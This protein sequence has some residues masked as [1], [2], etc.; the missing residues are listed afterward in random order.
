VAQAGTQDET[1]HKQTGNPNEEILHT[2]FL[3]HSI[4]APIRTFVEHFFSKPIQKGNERGKEKQRPQKRIRPVPPLCQHKGHECHTTCMDRT[5]PASLGRCFGIGQH[6]EGKQPQTTILK[7][8]AESRAGIAVVGK[9]GEFEEECG[10]K[11]GQP[12]IKTSSPE[13]HHNA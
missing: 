8:V 12:T 9:T 1:A 3:L 10:A 4:R 13:K 7:M 11:E 2:Y 5:R 6:I